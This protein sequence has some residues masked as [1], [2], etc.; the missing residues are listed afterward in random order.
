ME[1]AVDVNSAELARAMTALVRAFGLHRPEQT[2]CG[3][4]IGV[5]EAHTLIDLSEIKALSQG[6]LAQRLRLEKSTISRLVRQL[7]ARGWVERTALPEDGRVMMV[8]LSKEGRKAA[9]RLLQARRAKFTRL[10]AAIPQANRSAVIEAISTL[11]EAA[12]D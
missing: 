1:A 8:R 12:G 3:E 10:L 7:V 6:E 4:P 9:E 5:A 2:P 11:A